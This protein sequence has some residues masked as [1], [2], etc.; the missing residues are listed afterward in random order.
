[1]NV[2]LSGAGGLIGRAFAAQA[3]GRG[4]R[5][6]PLVRPGR[7][8]EAG[9]RGPAGSA[10]GSV[11]WDPVEGTVDRAALDRLGPFD[12]VVHL[13]GAGIGDARWTATRRRDIWESRVRSTRL[14]ARTLPTLERPPR[15][16]VSASAVGYYGDRGAEPLDETADPGTGFLADVCRAWE[17]EAE[18]VDDRLRVVRLRSGV[19]LA[20][21]GGALAKQLSLFRLGLGGRLGSGRQYVSWITLD[22]HLSVVRRA[23]DDDRLAGPVNATAPTPVTNAELTAALGRVLHRPAVLVVPGPALRLALG[24][25]LADELLLAGQRAV[26]A[27]LTAVDHP[28]AHPDIDAALRS[29]FAS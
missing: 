22:D 16:L 20:R 24:R 5:V 18:A 14:L 8:P 19:V 7:S 27:R 3:A 21:H 17:A 29:L 23:I 13:A 4:D 1:V 2:L 15:V 10:T 6:V 25:Q 11:P 9:A 28:F 26:P 12:A